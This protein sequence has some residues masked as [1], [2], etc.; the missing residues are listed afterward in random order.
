MVSLFA[1][2]KE[3]A[4]HVTLDLIRTYIDTV[5]KIIFGNVIYSAGR[6]PYTTYNL[7]LI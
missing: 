6:I 3:V 4:N 7:Y 2:G 5:E 1:R